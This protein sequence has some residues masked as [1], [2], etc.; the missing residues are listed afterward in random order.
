[1]KVEN[2]VA[3]RCT[4]TAAKTTKTKK[5]LRKRIKRI[6]LNLAISVIT[7]TPKT[8]AAEMQKKGE[9]LQTRVANCRGKKSKHFFSGFLFLAREV[10]RTD[11]TAWRLLGD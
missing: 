9:N 11:C 2:K 7:T 10:R 4:G 3:D 5:N 1:M 6:E 8:A